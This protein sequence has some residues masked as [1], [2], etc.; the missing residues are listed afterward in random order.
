VFSERPVLRGEN[1]KESV[2]QKMEADILSAVW[3]ELSMEG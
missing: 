1:H 3:D 2:A